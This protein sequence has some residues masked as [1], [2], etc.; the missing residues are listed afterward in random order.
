[1]MD[2]KE[3]SS[4]ELNDNKKCCADCKTTKTPLWR[5][6]PAG[7]KAQQHPF[8]FHLFILLSITP[9]IT[10]FFFSPC[11]LCATPAE[12]ATGREGVV[13]GSERRWWCC[14]GHPLLL[15]NRAGRCWEKRNRR[16]S[17]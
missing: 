14:T 15:R 12:S 9:S 11:R 1:M 10:H 17:V 7:P 8:L 16:L 4:S 5:G 3:W 2:L 13:P 6:G